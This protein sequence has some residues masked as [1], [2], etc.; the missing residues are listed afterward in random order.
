M[1]IEDKPELK[2]SLAG[3]VI[4]LTGAGGGIGLETAKAFAY[5]GAKIIIAEIIKDKGILAEKIINELYDNNLVEFYQIDLA[6]EKQIIEMTDYIT[7]KYGCPD[8][9][10]N[11]AT[12]T[13]MGAVDEVDIAFWD[14]S[15][16]VN[17]KAPLMLTQKFLPFM[18]ERNSGVIAFV[19][20]SGASPYM[21]AYEVFK[22]SQVELCNTLAMELENTNVHSYTIGPGLVKTE[23]AMNAIQIVAAKMGMS[24]EE[25][26]SMNSQHILDV[27]SAGVGFALSVMNADS[28]HGQEIGSI[29]VLMDYNLI[30]NGSKQA[31][32]TVRSGGACREIQGYLEK[33]YMTYEEQYNVWKSMNVFEKQ[34]VL[35]DFKKFMGLSSEQAYDKLKVINNNIQCGDY[36]DLS[37]ERMFFE[38][39][40]DYW[41][42]QLKLLQGYEKNKNKLQENTKIINGWILD[43][44]KVLKF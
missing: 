18:K 29:Q 37:S 17:L 43:I 39:L 38:H 10:F 23:T 7:K 20:S 25:F 30:E 19:S 15:Y 27:E 32:S 28:Y 6:V 44:E 1:L 41:K 14:K 35:R 24:I 5:L 4:L 36:Q 21:G 12:I 40:K 9:I 33:I 34:W 42:H 8:V 3:K 22:S 2:N 11:N 16:A 26:Y 31:N 13:K